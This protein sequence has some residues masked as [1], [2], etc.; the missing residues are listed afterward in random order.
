MAH[1]VSD[2]AKL[3]KAEREVERQY[4]VRYRIVDAID[5]N[6]RLLIKYGFL[7][8]IAWKAEQGVVAL[9]GSKTLADFRFSVFGNV[10]IDKYIGQLL[11]LIF[12]SSGVTYGWRQRQLRRKDIDRLGNRV[13]D[14]EQ[15][16][17][18]ERSSSK[19]TRVGTTRPEDKI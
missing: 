17:D 19:L 6:V 1:N 13:K 4:R 10:T 8:L 14:L 7:F 15:R 12:G 5:N 16:L 18:P 11:M 9:A 3:T 2:L